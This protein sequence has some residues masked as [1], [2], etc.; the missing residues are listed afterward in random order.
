MVAA[1]EASDVAKT[2]DG[3]IDVALNQAAD[4]VER[5]RDK[6]HKLVGTADTGISRGRD[7]LRDRAKSRPIYSVAVAA[8]AG[9][10]VGLFLSRR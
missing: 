6:A 8:G 2:A 5:V 1:N 7:F 3:I 9:L 10:L 4:G